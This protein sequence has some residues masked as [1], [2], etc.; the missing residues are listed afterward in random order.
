LQTKY[1]ATKILQTETD[2]KFREYKQFD[3][4]V[5]QIISARTVLAEGQYIKGHDTV[6]AELHFNI[7]KEIGGKLYNKERYDRVLKLG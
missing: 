6:C 1:H 5:Q 2:S 4:A 3:E 7:C